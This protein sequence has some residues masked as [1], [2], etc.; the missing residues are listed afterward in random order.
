M[1]PNQATDRDKAC[2]DRLTLAASPIGSSRDFDVGLTRTQIWEPSRSSADEALFGEFAGL[3]RIEWLDHLRRLQVIRRLGRGR[4]G[5]VL[6]VKQPGPFNTR[7]QHALKLHDP[8]LLLQSQAYEFEMER[9][10][11]QVDAMQRVHHPNLAQCHEFLLFG[12]VGGVLME[13]VDGVDVR[14]LICL[15][16]A[17]VAAAGSRLAPGPFRHEALFVAGTTR[18]QP[19][20]AFYLLRKIL[21]ALDVLHRIG[22][23]HSDIKPGNVMIDRFGTIKLIDFGRAVPTQGD[24]KPFLGTPVYMA[25]EAH[26]EGLLSPVS[27]LYSAGLVILEM[28]RGCRLFSDAGTGD[29][30][31]RQKERLADELADGLP[32]DPNLDER[33]VA[34]LRRLL[35]PDPRERFADAADA[36]T[37]RDGI[38]ILHDELLREQLACDYDRLLATCIEALQSC[39][40]S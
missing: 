16:A 30:L 11:R 7:T 26:R 36:D 15:R 35:A 25:P 31:V 19:G 18:W 29:E 24:N 39:R 32:D 21:R 13:L 5:V 38:R 4:Q 20:V 12:N 40:P 3:L 37:G 10:A 1:V 22:Y 33:H 8:G 17:D 2:S 9:I 14:K 27:D 23:I 6:E 34:I 28:L